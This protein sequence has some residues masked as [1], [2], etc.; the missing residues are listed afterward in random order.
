MREKLWNIYVREIFP[1]PYSINLLVY[2]AVP[3]VLTSHSESSCR[4][5]YPLGYTPV[6][7][8]IWQIYE[9]PRLLYCKIFLGHKR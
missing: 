1:V 8:P 2:S 5:V 7:M 9:R 6:F 4:V 3:V